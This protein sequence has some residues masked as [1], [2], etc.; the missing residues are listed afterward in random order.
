M[1]DNEHIETF[2][3]RTL[4]LGGDAIMPPSIPALSA[5]VTQVILAELLE[6]EGPLDVP[7]DVVEKIAEYLR[8]QRAPRFVIEPHPEGYVIA[9]KT[10]REE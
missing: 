2:V 3:R 6:R 8:D 9:V 5:L 1:T 7:S 10:D 4:S